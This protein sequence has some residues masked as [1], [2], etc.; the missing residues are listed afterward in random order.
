MKSPDPLDRQRLHVDHVH[1]E[2]TDDGDQVLVHV[3]LV[4]TPWE[5][6]PAQDRLWELRNAVTLVS[7]VLE[8]LDA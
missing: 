5:P 6:G 8:G 2:T 7:K 3:R 1:A 4:Y